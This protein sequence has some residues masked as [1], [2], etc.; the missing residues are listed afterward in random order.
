M[1]NEEQNVRTSSLLRNI[2]YIHHDAILP[3]R[4]PQQQEQRKQNVRV[5]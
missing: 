3:E 4:N 2:G 1:V 5:L